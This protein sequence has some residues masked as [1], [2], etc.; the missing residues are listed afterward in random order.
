MRQV[1]RLG[2][3]AFMVGALLVGPSGTAVAD[4]EAPGIGWQTSAAVGGDGSGTVSEA[5]AYWTPERIASARDVKVAKSAEHPARSGA[6]APHGVNTLGPQAVAEAAASS[7][8][9]V[10][11][12][13]DRP[14]IRTVGK[15]LY[16]NPDDNLNYACSGSAVNS[17]SKMMVITAAHCVVKGGSGAGNNKPTEM[18][19]WIFIPAFNTGGVEAPYGKF[20]K[21]S[22]RAWSMWTG[23]KSWEYDYA[24]VTVSRN[25]QGKTLVDAVGGNALGYNYGYNQSMRMVGYPSNFNAGDIQDHFIGV[26]KRSIRNAN[27]LMMEK[28][29]F[30]EGSSGGPWFRT[31]DPVTKTGMINGVTSVI[32]E[33]SSGNNESPRF[34]ELLK[35]LYDIQGPVV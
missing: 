27:M 32:H 7:G 14:L 17:P 25:T 11:N 2:W 26:T 6:P 1:G 10:D 31:Y 21:T 29:Y 16:Q 22:Y 20:A 19:N 18:K 23:G 24:F 4:Q 12:E 15:V 8:D 5:E 13:P 30:N 35:K 3:V 9:T 33:G 28:S 34:N